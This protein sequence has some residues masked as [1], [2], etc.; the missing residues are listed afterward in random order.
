MYISKHA[1]RRHESVDPAFDFFTAAAIALFALPFAAFVLTALILT[2][3]APAANV[4][5]VS[6][7][8]AGIT[9]ALLFA[10]LFCLALSA[11]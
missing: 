7:V 1:A 4:L 3:A 9:G 6:V 10:V 11:N 2:G 8:A 5:I